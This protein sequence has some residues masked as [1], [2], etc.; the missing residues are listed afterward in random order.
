M[1]R[2]IL[3]GGKGGNKGSQ[4]RAQVCKTN[5]AKEKR[6]NYTELTVRKLERC[7]GD[8]EKSETCASGQ[9]I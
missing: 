2:Q 9:L 6:L 7:E 3:G 1:A 4:A 8:I 5:R